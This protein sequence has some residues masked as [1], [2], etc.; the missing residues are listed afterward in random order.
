MGQ[1]LDLRTLSRLLKEV[2]LF[3]FIASLPDGYN[4]LLYP[5]GTPFTQEQC[6]R[7][8]LARAMAAQ[9]RLLMLDRVLDR[10]D[11][12]CL[13]TILDKLLATDAPWTLIVV[14]QL[15]QVIARCERHL[16][17]QQGTITEVATAVEYDR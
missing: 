12:R 7:L 13:P 11:R 15:P 14:S 5:H 17:I 16:Q 10:I 3:D 6:L 4:T 8:G 9:P 1:D 2:G